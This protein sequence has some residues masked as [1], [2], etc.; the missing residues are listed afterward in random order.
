MRRAQS[1]RLTRALAVSLLG[2][3][4]FGASGA[5]RADTTIARAVQESANIPAKS[6]LK[7]GSDYERRLE[8]DFAVYIGGFHTIDM[9]FNANLADSGY[10]MTVD[11]K[12][13]GFMSNFLDWSMKA[14]SEGAVKSDSLIPIKAGHD[15]LWRGKKRWIKLDYPEIGV[16]KA[17]SMPPPDGEDRS[18]VAPEDLIGARDLAGSILSALLRVGATEN[19]THSEPVFDGR[20]RYDLVFRQIGVETLKPTDYS[21]FGGKTVRCALSIR[22]IGGFRTSPSRYRL[23]SQDSA[24]VWIGRVFADAPPMPV[25]L[26][27]DTALGGLRAHLVRAVRHRGDDV[28]RL[29]AVKFGSAVR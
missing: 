5:L 26:E 21:P 18:I 1:S 7:Y 24:T 27:I 10:R 28:Q 2:G 3:L 9:A 29:S 14:Y 6:A 22:K 19:C 4:A 20:R 25:K 15:S 16:P 13:H 11:L 17:E 12:T 8:L 23:V